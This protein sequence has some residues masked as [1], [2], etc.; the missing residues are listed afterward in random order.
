MLPNP[1]GFYKGKKFNLTTDHQSFEMLFLTHMLFK[2]G[3]LYVTTPLLEEC[4]DDTHTPKMETSEF[5]CR[6]QNTLP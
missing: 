4:E 1:R 5:D 6:G 2:L 3:L